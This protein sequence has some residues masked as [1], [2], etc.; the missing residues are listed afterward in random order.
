MSCGSVFCRYGGGHGKHELDVRHPNHR[1]A[2]V[3]ERIVLRRSLL[4]YPEG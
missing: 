3:L 1:R 4:K 2:R